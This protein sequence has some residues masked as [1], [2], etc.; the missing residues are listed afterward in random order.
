MKAVL[1]TYTADLHVHTTLSPCAER[2]MVPER[3]FARAIK[4]GI[5]V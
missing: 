1:K 5:D 3:V 2:Q 4:A